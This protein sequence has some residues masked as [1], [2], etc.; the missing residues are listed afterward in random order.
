MSMSLSVN[1]AAIAG[2]KGNRG[3]VLP[4]ILRG[5]V[6]LDLAGRDPHD[7]DGVADHVTGAFFAF[8]SSRHN[9]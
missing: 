7:V 8:R 6:I 2:V 5:S 9:W 4:L 3:W 1:P